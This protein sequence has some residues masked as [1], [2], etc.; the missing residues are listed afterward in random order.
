MWTALGNGM[1]SCI[2]QI[3]F[4]FPATKTRIS[5][6]MTVYA[7][8]PFL[9]SGSFVDHLGMARRVLGTGYHE[10]SSVLTNRSLHILSPNYAINA[11][12]P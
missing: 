11:S 2:S 1:V 10:A 4:N 9:A 5:Y 12:G 3:V 8:N 6:F 7:L